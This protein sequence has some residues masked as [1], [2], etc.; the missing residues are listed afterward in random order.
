MLVGTVHLQ[1]SASSEAMS[2]ASR[3]QEK[4]TLGEVVDQIGL[5][6]A[7]VRAS[8]LGG[9]V[10]L[11]DGAELLLIGSVA[12]TLARSWQLSRFLKGFVV[13]VVYTGVMVGNISSGPLGAHLGRRELVIA[14][15]TGIFIFS[16]LSSTSS[17]IAVLLVWRFIV[18]WSIGIGQ[19]AWMAIAAEI[20]PSSWRIVTGGF[21]QT[22]FAFGELYAAFLLMNDDP[23]LKHL[24]WRR[25]IQLGAI[26]SLILMALAIP[27]LQQSP[28]YLQLK[29]CHAEAIKVLESMRR[30]NR[31]SD[32]SVDFRLPLN[33]TSSSTEGMLD[34]L[35]KQGK[36]IL[37]AK[38]ILPTM[39]VSFTCFELNL[40]YYGCIYAFPQ[41]LSDLV[42]E[43]AAQQLLVGALWEIPGVCIGIALGIMYLRKTGIKF[44]LTLAASVTLLF[45][46]G[47]NNRN[48]HWAFDIA[49]YAGYYGIKLSPN[50]GF[51]LVYQV[52]NEIYPAE[53]RTLGCGLCLA[54]G[55]LAAMLGP[56]L[57]EGLFE[58]TG[59]WLTFFLIMAGFAVFNL[60]VVDVIPETALVSYKDP[61]GAA[62]LMEALTDRYLLYTK[63]VPDDCY[64]VTL[65]PGDGVDPAALPVFQASLHG[66]LPNRRCDTNDLLLVAKLLQR[67][68][69]DLLQREAYQ[70]GPV[71]GAY[72][73]GERIHV[74]SLGRMLLLLDSSSNGVWVNGV[75]MATGRFQQLH[76]GDRISFLAPIAKLD[77]D[78]AT[79]EVCILAVAASDKEP[80]HPAPELQRQLIPQA[81]SGSQQVRPAQFQA[82]QSAPQAATAATPQAQ[83]QRAKPAPAQPEK[84]GA[85]RSA[86][87]AQPE[88][89]KQVQF[90]SAQPREARSPAVPAVVQ[91][92]Q[93]EQVR[94]KQAQPERQE[95]QQP[96]VQSTAS[97]GQKHASGDDVPQQR[98]R[99]K[100]AKTAAKASALKAA[101]EGS[102]REAPE[103]PDKTAR[104]A[105]IL[106]AKTMPRPSDA[107][108]GTDNE[109]SA[110]A[111][112]AGYAALAAAYFAAQ[113]EEEAEVQRRSE[114]PAIES[115][116]SK[117]EAPSCKLSEGTEALIPPSSQTYPPHSSATP[118]PPAPPPSKTS[119][120]ASAKAPS[121]LP[122]LSP[123]PLPAMTTSDSVP[124]S[125]TA[126][127]IESDPVAQTIPSQLGSA[128]PVT[129]PKAPAAVSER[130]P[131]RAGPLLLPPPPT[132]V[133][134]LRQELY[135]SLI[136]LD[137][138]L[139]AEV[140]NLRPKSCAAAPSQAPVTANAQDSN[141]LASWTVAWG[142]S[143]YQAR[144]INN[145]DDVDQICSEHPTISLHQNSLQTFFVDNQIDNKEDQQVFETA[146]LQRG[147]LASREEV[148]VTGAAHENMI[149]ALGG[150]TVVLEPS[151]HVDIVSRSMRSKIAIRR[152][153]S[154]HMIVLRRGSSLTLQPV[155]ARTETYSHLEVQI[156]D[157]SATWE[158]GSSWEILAG[159]LFWRLPRNIEDVEFQVF[160][161]LQSE[162]RVSFKVVRKEGRD[163]R[164]HPLARM[165]VI[166]AGFLGTKFLHKGTMYMG[167]IV[168]AKAAV[169]I[170]QAHQRISG[171]FGPPETIVRFEG[172]LKTDTGAH[173]VLFEDFGE[174]LSR[175]LGK[176]SDFLDA[177]DVDQ[178]AQDLLAAVSALHAQG[179]HHLA[180]S[181]ESV[182]LRRDG[183]GRMRLKLADL[184]VCER[185]SNPWPKGRSRQLSW[186]TYMAPELQESRSTAEALVARTLGKRTKPKASKIADSQVLGPLKALDI[187]PSL[188]KDGQ[189]GARQGVAR[190]QLMT[191]LGE[192]PIFAE[193][194]I[195]DL[196][197]LAREFQGPFFVPPGS[198][199]F[200]VGEIGDFLYFVLAG[201][202]VSRRGKKE[203]RRYRR[204]GFIGE[205]ALLGPAPTRRI[206]SASAARGGAGCGVLRMH[207]TFFRKD[208]KTGG[209][210]NSIVGPTRWRYLEKPEE[211][212]EP[213]DADVFAAGLLW[214]QMASSRVLS[215]YRL[216]RA[217]TVEALLD[218]VAAREIGSF[219]FL[220]QEW[221]N[222][223]LIQ[224]IVRRAPAY[225]ALVCLE[226]REKI[227]SE[228]RSEDQPEPQ[229]MFGF[230]GKTFR[231]GQVAGELFGELYGNLFAKDLLWMFRNPTRTQRFPVLLV[232]DAEDGNLLARWRIGASMVFES[233]LCARTLPRVL[234]SVRP[235]LSAGFQIGSAVGNRAINFKR[236]WIDAFCGSFLKQLIAMG[237]LRMKRVLSVRVRWDRLGSVLKES[238]VKG[239]TAR[240]LVLTRFGRLPTKYDQND[241]KVLQLLPSK[242]VPDI[243][244]PLASGIGRGFMTRWWQG[245][246]SG[247]RRKYVRPRFETWDLEDVPQVILDF[248][249]QQGAEQ[250]ALVASS[251]GD[252]MARDLG[253]WSG[254]F[255]GILSGLAMCVLGQSKSLGDDSD[256]VVADGYLESD[257]EL[258][259]LE[260]YMR[261]S[262]KREKM[263]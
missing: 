241:P 238:V 58:L 233:E 3:E 104:P 60:Y 52:A 51:V 63:S 158:A 45:I 18:G 224:L 102:K 10:W 119:A 135:T 250:A 54:C 176:N 194:E 170:C 62:A 98:P 66:R 215:M 161:V 47:G 5:G 28:T 202:I 220:L 231:A 81:A 2:A 192:F 149:Y 129:P 263:T 114:Q 38:L 65:T 1:D 53:A 103:A 139:G 117:E 11:A 206:F 69:P 226:E 252:T 89:Q 15:Y 237:R 132:R 254:T 96:H 97:Q 125:Q 55:R 232:R 57:F 34:M 201:E 49:L 126:P 19:P 112:A 42:A 75:R 168:S 50:I 124:V 199:L 116:A 31:A 82:V 217:R 17:T 148:S 216:K 118:P 64:P 56:L 21:S 141:D 130:A 157:V 68:L 247:L 4:P 113:E 108:Q 195:S 122:F 123:P 160:S 186:R 208:L 106:A 218:A 59:T 243:G 155:Q 211:S 180:L 73:S 133:P 70:N 234:P 151:S 185:P 67:R 179:L 219:Y 212:V 182:W 177:N 134:S 188:R 203:L 207:H 76:P 196:R 101:D 184:G 174:S 153:D 191:L 71:S 29:G 255:T 205:T 178:C 16:I 90:A 72:L 167:K 94:V 9:G 41:V 229:N 257:R 242:W 223:A 44:Y 253:Y 244:L 214:C 245:F 222:V 225:E 74:V 92:T 159:P 235:A 227:A 183:M 77:E 236:L 239:Q 93:P 48:R 136:N 7:Q 172:S 144:L 147:D 128:A 163:W 99:Q 24:N 36:T 6:P 110:E 152:K 248:A 39:V 83:P 204:G 115:T 230:V 169:E 61:E 91:G 146:I 143:K 127:A 105:K 181:P 228:S 95:H 187:L 84:P 142:L 240:N 27:F 162:G 120:T 32:V 258:I 80:G 100:R 140:M 171:A 46:I 213:A 33:P 156:A 209:P 40:L 189:T 251:V 86:T 260:Q 164:G 78:P 12:D 175:M 107:K 200:D 23:S 262:G 138:E 137:T 261:D 166:R 145:Y 246:R 111:M 121:S 210:L 79:W 37:G 165:R 13:T 26:P 20:T 150:E 87:A 35:W 30:D 193:L 109:D 154:A 131:W 22:M 25:V 249:R 88:E 43:G 14:S 85:G 256:L 8:L 221:R 259:A 198:S 173:L 197:Q 190:E